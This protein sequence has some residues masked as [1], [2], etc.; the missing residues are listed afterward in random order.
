MGTPGLKC[1][2]AIA[3][4]TMATTVTQGT[5]QRMSAKIAPARLVCYARGRMTSQEASTNGYGTLR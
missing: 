3:T 1:A 5:S 4:A 2:S